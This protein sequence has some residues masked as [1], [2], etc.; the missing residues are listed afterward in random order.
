MSRSS[1]ASGEEGV[2][3]AG[4]GV[5]GPAR[6]PGDPSALPEDPGDAGHG[7]APVGAP[8]SLREIIIRR[9][10]NNYAYNKLSLPEKSNIDAAYSELLSNSMHASKGINRT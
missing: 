2:V 4:V 1:A 5:S 10:Y 3:A 6:V 9:F 8:D 7:G